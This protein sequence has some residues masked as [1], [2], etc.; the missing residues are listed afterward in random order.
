MTW[1][2]SSCCRYCSCESVQSSQKSK[3]TAEK[4]SVSDMNNQE[5]L[6]K[7]R[8]AKTQEEL[9]AIA[10]ENGVEMDAE[11]AQAYFEQL[12]QPTGEVSDDELDDVA[13][14]ACYQGDGRMVTTVGNSC[15]SWR[16]KQHNKKMDSDHRPVC[17]E[18]GKMASCNSCKFCTYEKGLWLCNYEGNRK[19]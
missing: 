19:R 4:E 10:Q 15:R 1:T 11:S 3:V 18:C 7:A 5:M 6:A 8:K 16:C 12:H 9:L 2:I 14:G 13:G 17:I